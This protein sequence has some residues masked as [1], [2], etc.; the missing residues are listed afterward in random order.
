MND[1]DN[2]GKISF[3]TIPKWKHACICAYTHTSTCTHMNA[4]KDTHTHIT[5]HHTQTHNTS[6]GIICFNVLNQ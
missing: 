3:S 5:S 4:H 6:T 2:W 1:H